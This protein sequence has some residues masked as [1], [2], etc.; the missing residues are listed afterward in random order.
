M[1]TESIV[2]RAFYVFQADVRNTSPLTLRGANAVD[3]YDQP[4]PFDL[5]RTSQLM[6]T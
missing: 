2:S 4:R 6:P 5:S 3:S 1:R